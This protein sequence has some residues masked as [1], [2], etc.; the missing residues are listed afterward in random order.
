MYHWIAQADMSWC[1][2]CGEPRALLFEN[3]QVRA[4]DE[5]RQQA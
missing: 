2:R 4:T 3:Y 5:Y 1:L